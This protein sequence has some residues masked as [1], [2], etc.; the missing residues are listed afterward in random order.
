MM[1]VQQQQQQQCVS[2]RYIS[3]QGLL[4]RHSLLLLLLLLLQL[5][6]E[7]GGCI[8]TFFGRMGKP[9]ECDSEWGEAVRSLCTVVKYKL[10]VSTSSSCCC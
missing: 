8:D 1:E 3:L 7:C 4:L 9:P 5:N 10:Q 6:E 2:C